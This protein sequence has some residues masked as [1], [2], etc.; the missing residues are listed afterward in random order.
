MGDPAAG[1]SVPVAE[2]DTVITVDSDPVTGHLTVAIGGLPALFA[3]GA[4]N[5][6]DAE[7]SSSFALRPSD[8]NTPICDDLQKR[9]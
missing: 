8:G 2:G 7:V 4:P 3:F 1:P 5:L 9:R 6:A